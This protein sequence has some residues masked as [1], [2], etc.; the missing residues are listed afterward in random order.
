MS[1]LIAFG[2]NNDFGLANKADNP[3]P[4]HGRLLVPRGSRRFVTPTGHSQ[5]FQLP[6]LPRRAGENFSEIAQ[7]AKEADLANERR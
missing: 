2:V 1:Y 5:I 3:H 7:S 6:G 4:P